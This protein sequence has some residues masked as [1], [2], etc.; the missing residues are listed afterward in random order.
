VNYLK[1]YNFFE[2]D[3]YYKVY[4]SYPLD[5]VDVFEQ[6]Q[7]SKEELL[8]KFYQIH[9][10]NLEEKKEYIYHKIQR[11]KL[12]KLILIS[13]FFIVM[14]LILSFNDTLVL[15][16]LGI[17]SLIF[18]SVSFILKLKQLYLI[19]QIVHGTLYVAD[20]YSYE[21]KI[22]KKK[23]RSSYYM[24]VWDYHKCYLE[25]W[26]SIS[27]LAYYRYS[28]YHKEID[29]TLYVICYKKKIILEAI[30]YDDMF[31]L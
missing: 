13:I 11:W 12:V 27:S 24:R 3:S 30:P 14:G 21:I 31:V 8:T 2:K 4:T 29:A 25:D 20:S 5:Y 7:T 1:E 9:R 10:A 28:R 6:T 18:G 19:Y 16:Y 23:K 22:Q 17:I 15:Y 26:F